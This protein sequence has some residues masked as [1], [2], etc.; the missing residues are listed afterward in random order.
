[1][2]YLQSKKIVAL[3]FVLFI[4]LGICVCFLFFKTTSVQHFKYKE[5]KAVNMDKV[6]INQLENGRVILLSPPKNQG[7]F[8]MGQDS[9][10][11]Q[12]WK[13]RVNEENLNDDKRQNEGEYY[14]LYSY[15]L[16]SKKRK[17]K[18][19]VYNIIKKYY[20]NAGIDLPGNIVYY[21]GADYLHVV[22]TEQ[23]T[24]TTLKEVLINTETEAVI[25]YPKELKQAEI[26][27]TVGVGKTG[28]MEILANYSVSVNLTGMGAYANETTEI[29]NTLNLSQA[30][31]D[32]VKIMNSNQGRTLVRKGEKSEEEW[33]NIAMRWFA[34]AGEEKLVLSIK[35]EK[36]GNVT[37]INSYQDYLA[38]RETHPNDEEVK[39]SEQD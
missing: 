13:I 15:D 34:P 3:A 31:P 25:D 2:K 11:M 30:H 5:V 32:L 38:W 28:L 36:T 33:F 26:I 27:F 37:A 9:L 24:W 7:R 6:Q 22:L 29:P 16:N 39:L 20:P 8:E 12:A 21:Q 17:K 18:L 1:M 23:G 35:D 14:Y 19:N 4:L 10:Y